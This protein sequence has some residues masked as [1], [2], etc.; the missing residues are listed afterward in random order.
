MY[1]NVLRAGTLTDDRVI[2]RVSSNFVPTHFNNNDPTRDPGS[3]SALAWKA[4]I[5]QKP[6][7]GQGIWIIGPDGKVLGGMSAEVDGHPSEKVGAGP[8]APWRANPKFADACVELLDSSLT[9]FGEVKPR[10][11]R[12]EPL[13]FRGA[14]VKPDGSVRL[15][16]YNAAD[17]GLVFS[18]QLSK[19]D[20]A[21]FTTTQWQVGTRWTLPDAVAR[22]FAPVL[23]PYADTRFRPRP[24]D[25]KSA[26]L[27][28]EVESVEGDL[29]R[30]RLTGRWLADW[31]HD[32]N[33]HSVG[34]A[35]AD[36]IAVFDMEKKSL[37]S[38]LMVFDG[39]YNYA[40]PPRPQTVAAVVRWRRDGPAE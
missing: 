29:A 4:I 19:G 37:K 30:I 6:L 2:R 3:P 1:A 31:V 40:V 26:V 14:G 39:T 24:G 34:T 21:T 10:A 12:A 20:W 17:N 9:R 16:V 5:S 27:Q 11:A 23:S 33:E 8:G 38:L 25:L 7:Q 22:Q 32:G 15:V 28:A 13:P 18:A 36:G 35:S